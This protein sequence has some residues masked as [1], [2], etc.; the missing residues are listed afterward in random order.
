MNSPNYS[1]RAVVLILALIVAGSSV[2]QHPTN[3]AELARCDVN[4]YVVDQDPAGLNV[5]VAPNKSAKVIGKLPN[6]KVEGIRV[7][8]TGA[9][10]DW[11]RIDKALEQGGDPDRILF[12]GSGWIYSALLGVG[13]MAITEGGTNL[14][15]GR[16]TQSDVI[17]RIP[18][19]DD[20]IKVRGCSGRWLFVEYKSKR[21]WAAPGTLCSNSLTTCV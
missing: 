7:H 3:A 4:A 18:A 21:G 20:S 19:G 11:V 16:S 12:H 14:Y 1:L 8:I 13:G 10:G 9:S 17:I 15:Q 2:R 6:Q 5:R